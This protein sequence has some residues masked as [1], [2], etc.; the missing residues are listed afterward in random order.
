MLYVSRQDLAD[1]V[2]VFSGEDADSICQLL[3]DEFTK[4][5]ETLK[6]RGGGGMAVDQKNGGRSAKKQ[7]KE[8]SALRD[9]LET[10]ESRLDVCLSSLSGMAQQTLQVQQMQQTLQDIVAAHGGKANGMP[11]KIQAV[12]GRR[13]SMSH[14][15]PLEA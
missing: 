9:Q 12:P 4:S 7:R 3:Q 11:T 5:W 1:V 6:P 2:T 15:S 14:C 10:F 13:P 8:L